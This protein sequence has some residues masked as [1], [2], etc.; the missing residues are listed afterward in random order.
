VTKCNSLY[1]IKVGR[2]TATSEEVEAKQ[3]ELEKQMKELEENRIER[4]KVDEQNSLEGDS[5][6]PN[7]EQSAEELAEWDSLIEHGKQTIV[8]LI[9]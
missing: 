2:S 5:D 1:L 7:E 4:K 3:K 8:N 9:N 6:S